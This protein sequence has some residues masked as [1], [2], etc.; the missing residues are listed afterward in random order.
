M[1]I[2]RRQ[3]S[4]R[5]RRWS[6]DSA[7]HCC[8]PGG[9]QPCRHWGLWAGGCVRAVC[10]ARA[11]H[12]T[13]RCDPRT[14]TA[15]CIQEC[16]DASCQIIICL[17]LLLGLSKSQRM[18]ESIIF[19]LKSAFSRNPGREKDVCVAVWCCAPCA[20]SVN[21]PCSNRSHGAPRA[22]HTSRTEG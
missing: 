13:W 9:L 19:I 14:N 1:V 15:Q 16:W 2:W 21:S 11:V 22:Q 4:P 5:C 3:L 10:C 18:Q 6:T 12:G 7:G 20:D 17:Y 8:D